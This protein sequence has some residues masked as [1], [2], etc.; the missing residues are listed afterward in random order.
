M[1]ILEITTFY[2]TPLTIRNTY[3]NA[4]L[5]IPKAI[6]VNAPFQSDVLPNKSLAITAMQRK[7]PTVSI[8]K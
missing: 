6:I 5:K 2:Q 7:I 8:E 1:R 3:P 4:K